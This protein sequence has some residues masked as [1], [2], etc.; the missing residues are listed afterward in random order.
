M[1]KVTATTNVDV[2]GTQY[3][4]GESFEVDEANA[5][6]LEEQGFAV[7]SKGVTEAAPSKWGSEKGKK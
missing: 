2:G 7:P 3:K 4:A 1:A 6:W 5:K